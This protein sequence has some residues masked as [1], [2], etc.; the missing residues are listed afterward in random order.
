MKLFHVNHTTRPPLI[1]AV[2]MALQDAGIEV[3]HVESR[4]DVV[5]LYAVTPEANVCTALTRCGCELTDLAIVERLSRTPADAVT[6]SIRETQETY[7]DIPGG[8]WLRPLVKEA[9]P[10]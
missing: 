8:R 6:I 2:R 1:G 7:D 5:T 9:V 4:E 3:Y 10:A